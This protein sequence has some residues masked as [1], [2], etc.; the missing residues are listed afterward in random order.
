MLEDSQGQG[1]LLASV[2]RCGGERDTRDHLLKQDRLEGGQVHCHQPPW[3][4][5]LV[6]RV[7]SHCYNLDVDNFALT[8]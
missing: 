1:G 8:L 2:I 5:G 3:L 4:E 6:P 7:L